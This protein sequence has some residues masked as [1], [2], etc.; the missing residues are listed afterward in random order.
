MALPHWAATAATWAKP[1][2]PLLS[3][4]PVT[5]VIYGDEDHFPMLISAC[6][7]AN[8]LSHSVTELRA[9]RCQEACEV[10]RHE[11]LG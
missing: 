9:E 11:I 10:V 2:S 3:K 7:L 8:C 6:S 5:V 4:Y 1:L